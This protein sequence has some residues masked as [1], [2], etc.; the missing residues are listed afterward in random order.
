MAAEAM[1][2]TRSELEDR[3]RMLVVDG[4]LPMPRFNQ[5]IAVGDLT[6]E[7]DAVWPAHR[8]IVELDGFAAHGNR[9]AFVRDRRRDRN[10]H[11]AG[12]IVM[13]YAWDDLDA[14]AVRQLRGLLSAR[15][16]RRSGRPRSAAPR[17]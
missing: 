13:R 8:V 10:A 16:P 15:R 11:A 9:T 5:T 12:Y 4:G 3:F 2:R 1:A 17:A 6:I 14:R 7:S